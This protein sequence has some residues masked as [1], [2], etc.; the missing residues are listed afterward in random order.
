LPESVGASVTD[1]ADVGFELDSLDGSVRVAHGS[2][3]LP[4]AAVSASMPF[5][6]PE[7]AMGS[8]HQPVLVNEIVAWLTPHEGAGS[9]I[10]DGTVGGGGHTMALVRRL[11]AGGRLIGLDRDPA[12]LELADQAV[13]GAGLVLPVTLVHRAYRE[14]RTV[15]GELGI[16]QVQGVLLDLGLSSDQLAWRTR[17]FSF[18]ADGPLDMRF[19]PGEAAPS[20]AD[21]V[22]QM[23]ETDLAQLFFELGEERFSRRIARRIVEDRKAG[24][25]QTT[26]QLAELVRRAIPGRARHGPI[27]PATRV[28]QALRIAVN[29][30]LGQLDATLGAIPE[31][32]APGGRAAIISFHSLEDRRVKWAFK[33]NPK[34]VVLTKKPV[35]ATA[36]EV[37]VNPRARSAKLRVVERC[38]NPS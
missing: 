22:N 13:K 15:L 20:A 35:T 10:V 16:N 3:L 21:L 27:D 8:L 36:Q 19:D 11:G 5:L 6:T 26:G 31:L 38:P 25:I 14:I 2:C 29:D 30:E 33:A 12:M 9:I 28:F 17:G 1:F 34:L 7:A 23:R 37:A 18:A 24:P 4:I 32:L